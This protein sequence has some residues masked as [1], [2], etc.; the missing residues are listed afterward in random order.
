MPVVN[1]VDGWNL[2][3][4]YHVV[5]IGWGLRWLER[6]SFLEIEYQSEGSV[7]IEVVAVQ[8]FG[9]Q[10]AKTFIE[11]E[12]GKVVRLCLE[13]YLCLYLVA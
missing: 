3:D 1:V 6:S 12:R 4:S 8:T 5:C 2:L 10:E 9:S 7:A 11:F 13:C